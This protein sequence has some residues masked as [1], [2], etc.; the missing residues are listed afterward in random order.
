MQQDVTARPHSSH[1]GVMQQSA[2]PPATYQSAAAPYATPPRLSNLSQ[3]QYTPHFQ[4][5]VRQ[6]QYIEGMQLASP[7][8]FASNAG[9][10]SM[11]QF[12]QQQQ[13]QRRRRQDSDC[14][15]DMD[16]GN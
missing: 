16:L 10:H 3:T 13:Q 15:E 9:L 6:D 2:Q 4:S 7:A 5:P 1:S 14:T 8:S 11:A 12:Q